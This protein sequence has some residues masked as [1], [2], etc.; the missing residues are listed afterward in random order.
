[1]ST[2]SLAHERRKEEAVRWFGRLSLSNATL[3]DQAEFERWCAEHP[4]NRDTYTR[5]RQ[6]W[7]DLGDLNALPA[8][9]PMLAEAERLHSEILLSSRSAQ[10]NGKRFK[11]SRYYALAASFA[12]AVV[13]AF[14]YFSMP[15]RYKT[16]TGEI[17]S[18][19]LPDASRVTLGARSQVALEFD[20]THRRL[21]LKEGEAFFEVRRDPTRP[22]T[23]E[24]GNARISV[25][26]TQ[27]DVRHGLGRVEV[28]VVE[29]MVAVG[30][31][32][33]NPASHEHSNEIVLAAGQQLTTGN[34]L[35][36]A[37]PRTTNPLAPPGSWRSGRLSYDG[38]PLAEVIADV[39]RY[40]APGVSLEGSAQSAAGLVVTTAFKIDQIDPMMHS[41]TQALPLSASR[42]P[43][44]HFILTPKVPSP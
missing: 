3:A 19:T 8:A 5:A 20:E 6:L 34:A 38:A 33:E 10:S 15:D 26:G 1:M 32:R 22:F 17:R 7:Q 4:E 24:A 40:Y 11:K 29:G 43:D 18:I 25:L 35:A 23:V 30:R 31:A 37:K 36:P 14:F 12:V 2:D 21:I 39:N 16:G 41:L 28:A 42:D 27:F 9:R 13:G 44:G